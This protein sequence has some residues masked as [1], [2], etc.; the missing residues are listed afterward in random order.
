ML[1]IEIQGDKRVLGILDKAEKR[2]DNPKA[3]LNEIGDFIVSEFEANFPSEGRRLQEPWKKLKKETIKERIRLGF[4]A[5]P[6]L[7]RTGK[8]MRGFRKEVQKFLV[9]V[10]NPIDYF[11]YHQLGGGHL[12]QRRMILAPE[13]FKQEIVAIIN[14]HF[15]NVFK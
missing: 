1:L 10:K 8:L 9:R 6:I 3:T 11:K 7:V 13:R 5:S 4:G 15:V 14:K 12:P 2:I